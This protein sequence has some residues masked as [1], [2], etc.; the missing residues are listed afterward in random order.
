MLDIQKIHELSEGIDDHL[1]K[2]ESF[3]GLLK[4]IKTSLDE[5]RHSQ[6]NNYLYELQTFK[7]A[8]GDVVEQLKKY[9]LPEASHYEKD[10]QE[11][12]RMIDDTSWPIAVTADAIC[13]NDEKTAH[14]AEWILDLLVGE[15]LKNKKFLDYGCGQGDTIIAAKKREAK[16]ALGYDVNLSK[17]MNDFTDDFQIVRNLAPFDVILLHDVLDHIVQIDPIAALEQVKSVLSPNGRVYVR[18]HPW[19]A[20][21]GGHLYLKKNKAFLHL[22]LDAVELARLGGWQCDHNIQV[23]TPLETYRY[24]LTK[25]D[26]NIISEIVIRD[27]VEEFFLRPSIL[28]DRISKHFDNPETMINQLEISFVEYVLEPNLNHQIF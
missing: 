26:F 23:I 19:S 5:L 21:H 2:L 10:L 4:E 13:D 28:R 18:N 7:Q 20:R 16:Y 8:F 1:R 12:R 14:R 27:N 15:H 6:E 17:P 24:W 25:T 3:T 9:G 22:A 11:I